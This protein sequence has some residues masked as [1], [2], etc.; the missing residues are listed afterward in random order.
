ME[1]IILKVNLKGL[2]VKLLT[3]ISLRQQV[4]N[5]VGEDIIATIKMR[6]NFR[7]P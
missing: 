7:Y 6:N 5:T 4:P 2:P 3:F 1:E